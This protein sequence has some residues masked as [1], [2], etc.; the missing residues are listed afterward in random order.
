MS[1]ILENQL[2]SLISLPI[3]VIETD[4]VRYI[5]NF[6][7]DKFC[8]IFTDGV[9]FSKFSNVMDLLK[10][11]NQQMFDD[12]L[13][14]VFDGQRNATSIIDAKLN[15]KDW[16]IHFSKLQSERVMLQFVNQVSPT[17]QDQDKFS[18]NSKFGNPFL[19]N[20]EAVVDFLENAPRP[21]HVVDQDFNI[22]WGNKFELNVLGYEAKD[23]IGHNLADEFLVK[24]QEEKQRSIT[25][26][27]GGTPYIDRFVPY[28][29]INSIHVMRV[30]ANTR[31]L[32]GGKW[33][34][35]SILSD[36]SEA[37]QLEKEKEKHRKLVEN[38]LELKRTFVRYISHEIRSPLNVLYGGLQ[39]L[40]EDPL[41][42]TNP[43]LEEAVTDLFVSST[44]AIEILNCVL[45]YDKIEAGKFDMD[46][47]IV[48]LND[49][50]IITKCRPL[51]SLA[52]SRKIEFNVVWPPVYSSENLSRLCM[53]IDSM[54]INQVIRNIVSNA[55]KFSSTG[56]EVKLSCE[57]KPYSGV[58]SAVVASLQCLI[59]DSGPGISLE[60]RE[61]LFS[62]YSQFDPSILQGGGGS[63]LGLWISK[64][65][66]DLHGGEISC[67]S[68]GEDKGSTFYFSIPLYEL[69]APKEDVITNG[70]PYDGNEFIVL[71][72]KRKT[73]QTSKVNDYIN[74]KGTS[75][76][77]YLVVDDSQLNRKILRR[78]IQS[79]V[80]NCHID[81]ADDGSTALELVEK[82]PYHFDCIFLDFVMTTIHGAETADNI[83]NRLGYTGPIVGVTGN[84]LPEDIVTFKAAGVD[85]VL[86]KPVHKDQ[87]KYVI[88]SL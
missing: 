59:S 62:Q 16:I 12:L 81:E 46:K 15:G 58:E 19:D 83:R 7:N 70:T 40:A 74:Q 13:S 68:D 69:A 47:K 65:I 45:Q 20:H 10:V 53:N 9:D 79:I 22:I 33:T 80:Q 1:T 82:V 21:L 37:L 36:D 64:V 76:L 6:A 3:C 48:P 17:K 30:I 60:N 86:T 77:H 24:G 25:S 2:L 28:K 43:A 35:R 57:I 88:Q 54:R 29:G 63:G 4:I 75:L 39:L 51:V 84:A 31:Q 32:G 56:D 26:L 61:K 85:Y 5:V 87:L 34:S 11:E 38:M 78:L 44:Q 42:K 23:F 8:E 71:N 55:I 52:R 49:W 41:T 73:E 50:D 14:T 72:D 27:Q 67:H 66:V 18:C